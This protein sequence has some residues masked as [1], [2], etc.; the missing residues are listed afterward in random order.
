MFGWVD[1]IRVECN[2]MPKWTTFICNH[3]YRD[4]YSMLPRQRLGW[5]N[6]KAVGFSLARGQWKIRV[7]QT[8]FYIELIPI[9]YWTKCLVIKVYFLE[10]ISL[11]SSWIL[12]HLTL[13]DVFVD[14]EVF[15]PTL[16]CTIALF[17]RKA[18]IFV[19]VKWIFG[20]L[21]QKTRPI[22]PQRSDLADFMSYE[23]KMNFLRY[24]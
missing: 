11:C 1:G 6:R 22:F 13:S 17:K 8:K 20:D 19:S 14:G 5:H 18:R 21:H 9:Q 23:V 16:T 24:S 3:R 2:F 10:F 7:W 15:T 12:C 4:L